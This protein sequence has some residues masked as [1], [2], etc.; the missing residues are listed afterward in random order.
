M[1]VFNN[2][3]MLHGRHAFESRGNGGRWFRGCYVNI[4]EFSNRFNL[5][6]RRHGAADGRSSHLGNQDWA[7][8]SVM[9]R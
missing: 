3:R 8:G 2:R 6:D 9:L 4:D 1:L 7:C 5:L